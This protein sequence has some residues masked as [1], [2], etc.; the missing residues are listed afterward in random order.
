MKTG[1]G[2]SKGE[3]GRS[4]QQLDLL[5]WINGFTALWFHHLIWVVQ[6]YVRH[7]TVLVLLY[8]QMCG[9]PIPAMMILT[10]SS[11]SSNLCT[12]LSICCREKSSTIEMPHLYELKNGVQVRA[13]RKWHKNKLRKHMYEYYALFK[14]T[15]KS[16][17]TQKGP[18]LSTH[19]VYFASDLDRD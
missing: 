14:Q 6:V 19:P 16:V 17:S 2:G 1:T 5:R 15:T 8:C 7:T 9:K 11:I 18:C 4:K 3:G 13:S 12:V 10:W